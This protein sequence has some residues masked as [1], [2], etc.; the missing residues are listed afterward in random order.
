MTAQ[1]LVNNVVLQVPVAAPS[2]RRQAFRLRLKKFWSLILY[3]WHYR[4]EMRMRGYLKS[5]KKAAVDQ[6]IDKIIA[7]DIISKDIRK[8]LRFDA[9]SSYIPPTN[10]NREEIRAMIKAR[11][12]K[13]MSFLNIRV[14]HDLKL[15]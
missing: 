5:L 14:T 3:L 1:P 2:N 10:R 13:K 7:M 6:Q 11:H 4:R 8:A 15:V 9:R 12:A